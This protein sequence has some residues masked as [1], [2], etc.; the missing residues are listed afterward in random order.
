MNDENLDR[1]LTENEQNAL[2]S[3]ARKSVEWTVLGGEK[4]HFDY[5]FSIFNENR[6]A[7]VTLSR[8][9]QLRGCI[10]FVLAVKPLAETVA[11]MAAA[12]AQR[13]PRFTPV[14][15]NELEELALEIS[16]LSP[17]KEIDDPSEI[18]VGVHG[19]Y[20]KNGLYS[21]LLLPQVAEKHNWDRLEFL[22]HT[23]IKAGLPSDAWQDNDTQLQVFSAQV[24]GEA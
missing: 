3:I 16:V 20:I 13:D 9:D 5:D 23:C 22:R 11:E 19:L 15:K 7:F 6:G 2:L 14:E 12:A 17:F 21:G 24:F 18:K 4:P 8:N 10:G 1:Q